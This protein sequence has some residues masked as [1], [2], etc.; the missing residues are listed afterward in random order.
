[1]NCSVVVYAPEDV[2]LHRLIQRDE[3]SKDDAVL[4]M[5]SQMPLDAKRALADYVIDNTNT[6]EQ[7]QEQ[8]E[9]LVQILKQRKTYFT[10]TNLCIVV[11]VILLAILKFITLLFSILR[12]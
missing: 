11:A 6:R 10:R 9:K 2:Q 1:M 4:K 3:V 7:T 8:V 12:I 5:Q